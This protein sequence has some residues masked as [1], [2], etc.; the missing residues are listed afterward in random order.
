MDE[1]ERK[2][3][4]VLKIAHLLF[5]KDRVTGS[6]G[7]ISFRHRD[8]I[9]ISASG[10]CFGWLQKEDLAVLGING[11]VLSDRRP[12]KEYPLHLSIYQEKAEVGAVLHTHSFYSTLWSCLEHEKEKDVMPAVTPYLSMKVGRIGLIPEAKP[13]SKE[14]FA[15][16]KERIKDSDGY[17]L[18]HHG[19]V[20][21]DQDI[22][23]VYYDLEEME[24][25]AR[26][27]WYLRK[28]ERA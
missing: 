26:I 10:S 14:L 23:S 25:N 13:G 20:L 27:N 1:L 18:A 28:E 9:Y 8:R 17:L 12:S 21:A 22:R 6:T 3:E 5:E 19:V 24:E 15:F 2:Y 4:D 16:F 7:N 11:E